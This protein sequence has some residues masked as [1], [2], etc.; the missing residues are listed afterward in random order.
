MTSQHANHD[1]ARPLHE[2]SPELRQAVERL[3]QEPPPEGLMQRALDRARRQATTEPSRRP[4]PVDRRPQRRARPWS[5]ATA[6][7]IAIAACTLVL[8][9]L[10]SPVLRMPN[11]KV[12][13]QMPVAISQDLPTAWAYHRAIAQSPEAM[14]ALLARHARE[15]LRPEAK[16]C[17]AQ[18]FPNST[19]VQPFEAP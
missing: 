18:V 6:A 8:I 1:N 17:M 15:L 19:T 14:D 11:P 3:I 16:H 2:L 4:R 7:S 10:S 9:S 12:I 13:P 5:F